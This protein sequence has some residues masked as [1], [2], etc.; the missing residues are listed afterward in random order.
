MEFTVDP[1]FKKTSADFDEGGAMGLLMNHL[2]IDGTGRVVFDAS[3]A[4]KTEEDEDEEADIEVDMVD[5]SA[6]REAIPTAEKT[7]ELTI[8]ETL[9]G[10]Q[11]T[12]D[13]VDMPD[14]AALTGLSSFND[15]EPDREA[16]VP[17]GTGEEA[18]FFGGEDFDAG[19]PSGD[20]DGASDAGDFG[21]DVFG[22]G[23]AGALGM[24][25]PG[26]GH[27]PFDPRRPGE[28]VMAFVNGNEGDDMF[29]YFD[30]GFSKQWAGAEHWKLKKVSR[31]DPVQAVAREKKAAK[32]PFRIDFL[33]DDAA[34]DT[35]KLFT[36]GTRSATQLPARK[37]SSRRSA[38]AKRRD[39]FLLPDDMHF[40][41][42]QLLRLFLKPKYALRMRKSTTA[43]AEADGEIDEN[44][45]AQAAADR[46]EEDEP[47]PFETQFFNDG[48]DG[49]DDEVYVESTLADE[50]DLLNAPGTE[51]RR[52]RPENVH[53]AK[54]AKRVDVKRLK[55]DIWSGLR[56]LVEDSEASAAETEIQTPKKEEPKV[57]NTVIQSL[58]ETYPREKMGEISTSF[59]FI[60][61]LHLAN[62]EGLRLETA[63]TDMTAG[64][65][66]GDKIVGE[67]Q[68]LKVYK[69]PN[70]GRAA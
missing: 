49:G 44:F 47:P 37:T 18:D 25:Q 50:E 32:E 38:A 29:D 68:A 60:C 70:A 64:E 40:D 62:E 46:I 28:L 26:D 61:L 6:L 23:P 56:D 66:E 11:F 15:E 19:G 59:C 16:S 13:G 24:A 5:I 20:F 2:G 7:A 69:D 39:E 33:T 65:G 3:D 14:L 8:S 54:K 51:L 42:R 45:W 10:F 1:L 43:R 48:D 57:F 12:S 31:K 21:E 34:Q 36:P 27:G 22:A 58:R 30:R 52:A 41:S 63:R 35:R 9:A 17:A 4:T 67:L 53:Y 55:D